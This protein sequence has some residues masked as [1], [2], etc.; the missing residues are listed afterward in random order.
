MSS[1]T[2]RRADYSH[3]HGGARPSVG[4]GAPTLGCY[5]QESNFFT[6]VRGSLRTSLSQ[7][8]TTW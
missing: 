2:G 4:R 3:W 1:K 6:T 8:L 7:I 5:K